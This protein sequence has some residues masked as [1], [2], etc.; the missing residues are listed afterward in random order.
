MDENQDGVAEQDIYPGAGVETDP[1]D[2]SLVAN[3]LEFQRTGLTSGQT[4]GFKLRAY[5][6]RGYTESAWS[7]MKAAGEPNQMAAPTQNAAS[8]SST[9]I[10]LAW[11][12]PDMQG[13]TAVGFKA[14]RNSGDG[15]SMSTTADSTC[16]METKPAPQTCTLTGLIAGE[17]YTVQML[18][19]ND[20]GEGALST[21]ATLY[22]A[23]TPAQISDLQNTASATTP[24][25]TFSWTAPSS[26]GAFIFNYE[27]EMYDVAGGTTQNWDAGG[28]QAAPYTTTSGVTLTGLGLVA[29]QQYKFRVRAVN[30]MGSGTWSEWSSLTDPPRGFAL[31]TPTT[32]TNFGRHSDPAV[33]GT[34]KVGWDA[35]ATVAD[36]GGDAVASVTYEVYAGPTTGTMTAQTL[37]SPTDTFFSKAVATGTTYYFQMRS[38]NSAGLGSTWAGPISLV[39]AEVPGTPTLDSVTSTTA[40]QVVMSWTPNA[41][42]GNSVILHFLVSNDNFVANSVQVANTQTTYTYTL[43]NSGATVTYYVKAVNSVG[44][45]TAASGSVVV[46]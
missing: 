44:E 10:V 20:V 41:N 36:A 29:A 5:N 12:V 35:I 28:T 24:S 43:Q 31:D 30:K 9:T 38:V 34:I 13:G 45:S 7:Y 33:S 3:V 19:I 32:P 17:T 6:G 2:S 18:A 8:G 37:G 40:A 4:Y 1:L 21:A 23:A 22:A 46:A 11:T 26:N 27:G 16:G 15:T 42:D 39:S 14:Y 25:L